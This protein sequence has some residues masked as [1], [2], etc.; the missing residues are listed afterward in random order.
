MVPL[1]DRQQ[2]L[3]VLQ[4]QLADVG[5]ALLLKGA[6]DG[7]PVAGH[8]GLLQLQRGVEAGVTQ[9]GDWPRGHHHCRIYSHLVKDRGMYFG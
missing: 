8:R 2:V 3:A 1:D 4:C 7:A 6:Q 9:I 5:Q